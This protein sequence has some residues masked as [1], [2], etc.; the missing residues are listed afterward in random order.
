MF[1]VVFIILRS[2]RSVALEELY[3][4]LTHLKQANKQGLLKPESGSLS[5]IM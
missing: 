5:L 3:K 2:S 1:I 4:G